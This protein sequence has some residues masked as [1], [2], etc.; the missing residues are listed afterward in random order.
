MAKQG[1][2]APKPASAPK[3][4]PPE[5]P[6]TLTTAMHLTVPVYDVLRRVAF[7]RALEKGGRPSVS[8]VVCG[9]VERHRAELEAELKG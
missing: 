7:K 8:A 3:A 5:K 4:D 2:K 1:P 6:G 9:L